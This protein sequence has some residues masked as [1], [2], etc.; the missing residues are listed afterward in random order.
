MSNHPTSDTVTNLPD[1]HRPRCLRCGKPVDAAAIRHKPGDREHVI[2]EYECHGERASQ[3]VG[4]GLAERP[5]E[6]A[7]YTAYNEFTSGLMPGREG[8]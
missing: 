6:L 1:E 5:E 8:S 4:A 3:E 7:G 2:V